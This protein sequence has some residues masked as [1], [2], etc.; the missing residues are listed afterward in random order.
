M[1]KLLLAVPLAAILSACS[2][3][4]PEQIAYDYCI[5][6]KQ[7]NWDDARELALH[8]VVN[9]R[10]KMFDQNMGKYSQLFASQNCNV[11]NVENQSDTYYSIYFGG[12][13]LDSVE[14]EWNENEEEFLVTS[15]AFT[16]DLKLY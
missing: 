11:T 15:D 12:S 16:N 9:N 6:V 14:I 5:A 13:K 10:E 7:M 1:K 3:N 2:S 8:E 4:T